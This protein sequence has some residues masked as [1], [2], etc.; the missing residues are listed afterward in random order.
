MRCV[1]AALLAAATLPVTRALEINALVRRAAAL[2]P[3]PA[4][5]A[6]RPADAGRG[7]A[8][9]RG[10]GGAGGG[11][12]GGD[13]RGDAES[14]PAEKLTRLTE[15]AE[16]D[17]DR[18]VTLDDAGP[19]GDDD[20]RLLSA[21]DAT[22]GVDGLLALVDALLER[23]ETGGG[24]CYV[25]D[26]GDGRGHQVGACLLAFLDADVDGPAALLAAAAPDFGWKPSQKR[27]VTSIAKSIATHRRLER[28]RA[29][30][31]AGMPKGFL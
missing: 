7:V 5:E 10:G 24:A 1:V 2:P 17:F 18:V 28:D 13:G 8:A 3:A 25:V 26:A 21:P 11:A 22:T 12:G 30:V 6:R 16:V 14:S 23:W 29:M 4:A 31:D 20:A 27:F 9:G 15:G 19:R